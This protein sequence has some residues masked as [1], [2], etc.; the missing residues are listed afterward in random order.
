QGYG[1]RQ[2]LQQLASRAPRAAPKG[3]GATGGQQGVTGPT[4]LPG[5]NPGGDSTEPPPGPPPVAPEILAATDPDELEAILPI[6]H[7][8]AS[9]V[10]AGPGVAELFNL[11]GEQVLA[12][13]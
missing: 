7:L 11:A 6:L 10:D 1:Q 9:Q 3:R 4:G 12:L 8:I 5:G 2:E 13:Q